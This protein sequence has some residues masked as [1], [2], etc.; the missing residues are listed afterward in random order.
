MA[1][2]TR[3]LRIACVVAAMMAA[4]STWARTRTASACSYAAQPPGFYGF[5]EDGADNVPTDVV[6]FY[7]QQPGSADLGKTT[8][9]LT[10]ADGSSV[11]VAFQLA[12]DWNFELVPEHVLE[13]HTEYVLHADWQTYAGSETVA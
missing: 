10:A 8:F 1:T 4:C 11:A 9:S 6:P 13:P 2:G 5:P 7:N 12:D 3:G